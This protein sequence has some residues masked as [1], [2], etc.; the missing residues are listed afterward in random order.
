M[1]RREFLGLA[2]G[3]A[4]WPLTARAQQPGLPVIGF[5]HSLSSSYIEH[6]APAVRQGLSES[7]FVEG[8]SVAVEY[9]SAEGQY[10]R[11]P[12]LVADL[13][14]RKVS[15]ILA[16]GG[17]DPG[18]VA[19][20]ATTT[21]PIVFVSAADPVKAGLI[22]SFNRPGGNITGVSLIGSALEAKRLELLHQ[23]VPA[24]AVIGAL[25]NPKYPDADLQARELRDAAGTI[26][27]QIE[28]VSASTDRDLDT[29]VAALAEHGARALLVV[30]DPFF[31]TRREQLVALAARHNLPA[32]YN[33]REYVEIG[34]LAS[35]GTNFKD[36]YRQA[37]IMAGKILKGASPAELP[38]MQPTSFELLINLKTAKAL[39]LEVPATLLARADEV[40]E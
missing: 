17:S 14:G 16:A 3:A 21:I 33:Q 8:Q 11:L 1:R 28:I 27:R 39:G 22:T 37:G 40:I 7:G 12:A 20:A 9:R 6:F 13:V 24:P 10:D 4:A 35:Y 31:N 15:L 18:K 25:V 38:V 30:Q 29:A 5:L 34:G 32:I 2:G 19:K 36:G 23:L 26:K